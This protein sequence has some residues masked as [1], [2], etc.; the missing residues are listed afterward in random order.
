VGARQPPPGGTSANKRPKRAAADVPASIWRE[1]GY[2]ITGRKR[3]LAVI[4]EPTTL[5]EALSSD[6]A[7]LWQQAVNDEMASLIANGT[8]SLEPLPS[9]VTPI[10]VK[11]VFKI[12]RDS[13]GNIERYKA[14]LVAKGFRQREGID[15]TE[16][17]APVS[18][19]TTL[20][21]LLAV[22]AYEDLEIHQLDEPSRPPS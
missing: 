14:R 7:E 15:Y 17:F 5:E 10:P 3:N 21:T 1:E 22:A 13:A 6:Q 18:K 12:K 4:D 9:G 16:V 11:W 2:K 8:W 20:R 19:Y